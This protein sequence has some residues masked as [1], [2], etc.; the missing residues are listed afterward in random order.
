[1]FKP[2]SLRL[3]VEIAHR[4]C[5]FFICKFLPAN[6][7]S[8]DFA[9]NLHLGVD[10]VVRQVPPSWQRGM[11]IFS[12]SACLIF[13][14]LLLKG[15]WDYWYPF[16]TTRAFL[17]TDDI[18]MPELLQ[19]LSAILN[20][21]ERYEKLPRFIPYFALPLGMFLLTVRVLQKGVQVVRGDPGDGASVRS[22]FSNM[23]GH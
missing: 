12:I 10:I 2:N 19:F 5:F 1:M 18:P 23:P 17:E 8:G 4:C 16:V 11:E 6:K 15:S 14:L 13:S 3:Y 20:E 9:K 22:E 21:G 7:P